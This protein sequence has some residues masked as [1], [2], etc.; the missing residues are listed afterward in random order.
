LGHEAVLVPV[1]A[2]GQAKVRLAS[3]LSGPERAELARKMASRVVASAAGLP[4]AVVCDDAE[5]A[6][7]A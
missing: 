7:W 4:V 5:V 3:A 1:K 2:F 6:G